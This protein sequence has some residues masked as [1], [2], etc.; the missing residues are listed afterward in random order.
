M[1]VSVTLWTTGQGRL[2]PMRRSSAS[3]PQWLRSANET[4]MVCDII[5]VLER[6]ASS[7]SK[8]VMVVTED[9]SRA[10]DDVPRLFL[11][12]LHDR[13]EQPVY[14]ADVRHLLTDG[15][16]PDDMDGDPEN[17]PASAERPLPAP[18]RR[19]TAFADR[20]GRALLLPL[21]SRYVVLFW[22]PGPPPGPLDALFDLGYTFWDVNVYYLIV[23]PVFGRDVRRTVYG[24]WQNMSIYKYASFALHLGGCKSLFL[25]QKK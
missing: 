24:V 13:L 23:V 21:R 5:A 3:E 7:L 20:D 12:T 1:L 22:G 9:W 4:T 10:P 25:F 6:S 2:E 19:P 18:C 11:H 17:A 8:G 14:T 15:R 16:P